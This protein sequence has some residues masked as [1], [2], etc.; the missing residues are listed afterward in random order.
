MNITYTQNIEECTFNE[1]EHGECFEWNNDIFLKVPCFVDNSQNV[2]AI[3]LGCGSRTGMYHFINL[4]ENVIPV[5]TELKVTY[6]C[7]EVK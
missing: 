3:R 5:S 4:N 2:N 7:E 1:I 6:K